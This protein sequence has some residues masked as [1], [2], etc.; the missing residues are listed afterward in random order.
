MLE[1]PT[2]GFPISAVR[3]GRRCSH[4]AC[5]TSS[6][7]PH[8]CP[9][10]EEG[11]TPP[12]GGTSSRIPYL[13]P[14][15]GQ[16]MF[17]SSW[18]SCRQDSLCLP[19]AGPGGFSSCWWSWLQDSLSLLCARAEEIALLLGIPTAGFLI[20]ALR[21][22][23]ALAQA[24]TSAQTPASALW[25]RSAAGLNSLFPPERFQW[26]CEHPGVAWF[27]LSQV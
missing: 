27:A 11:T 8:P 18:R 7:V 14:W 25:R 15:R 26:H 10:R 20:S 12:V 1:A 21:E 4:P 19:C 17:S 22:S 5:D 9:V 3:G 6:R 2:A 16:K 23:R 13:G 24:L